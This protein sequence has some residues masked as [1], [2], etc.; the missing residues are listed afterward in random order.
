[1]H[2]YTTGT[3]IVFIVNYFRCCLSH[4]VAI[5]CKML[6]G[7]FR[8]SFVS[9]ESFP[10]LSRPEATTIICIQVNDLMDLVEF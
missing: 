8:G 10:A 2:S 5:A 1:M 9:R 4:F 3:K 7:N 6:S